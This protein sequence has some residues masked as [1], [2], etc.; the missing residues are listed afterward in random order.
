MKNKKIIEEKIYSLAG[1][2]TS[3]EEWEHFYVKINRRTLILKHDNE[4]F[5]DLVK[6]LE[7][8]KIINVNY[9]KDKNENII[10]NINDKLIINDVTI[11]SIKTNSYGNTFII[12]S[13]NLCN[14]DK[15]NENF[16]IMLKRSHHVYHKLYD[17]LDNDK[18]VKLIMFFHKE[19]LQIIDITAP[20]NKS[21]EIIVIGNINICKEIKD[22]NEFVEIVYKNHE[23]GFRF[24]ISKSLDNFERQGI[25]KIT[26]IK[27]HSDSFYKIISY[28]KIQ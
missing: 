24:L 14:G 8:N 27:F 7:T 17:E 28:E 1:I 6:F 15:N 2:I 23:K 12:T 10:I 5:S 3:V 26:Y 19:K 4:N 25:Y 16:N 18:T 21:R 22:L 11:K 9:I 20:T 13:P